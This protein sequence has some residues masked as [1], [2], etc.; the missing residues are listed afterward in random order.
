[1]KCYC[2]NLDRRPDRWVVVRD[3]L[4]KQ[5]L[6][7]TRFPAIDNGWRGC[8]DSHLAI[9]EQSKNEIA[10]FIFEDDVKFLYDKAVIDLVLNKALQQIS[11]NWDCL[12]LGASPQEPQERYSDNLFRLKNAFTTH[13]ILWHNRPNG[14]IEYILKNKDKINKIDVFL[15][16]DVMTRFNCFCVFPILATQTDTFNSDT[17]KRSDV[18]TILKNFNLYCG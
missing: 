18:S 12:F 11:F 7:I 6:Q 17:C 3:E 14:A 10:Y 8:R 2:I 1:M 15:A 13:A 5:G 16:L 4:N 9:M